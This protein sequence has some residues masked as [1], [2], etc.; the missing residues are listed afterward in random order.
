MLAWESYVEAQA[1]RAQGWTISAIARHLG[2]TRLTV[3]RYLSGERV[4]GQRARTEPDPFEE[5]VEYCRLRL[6]ADPH[7]WATTLFDEVTALG[8]A[9][10]Y[11]SFTRALRT[12]ELRPVCAACRSGK[13]G[14]RA[15]IDHPAG[16]ETQWDYLGATRGRAWRVNS[17]I[18]GRPMPD[19]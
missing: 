10:S 15:V 12:R 1:L 9:G 14:Q 8:Y 6:V 19:A 7:L 13:T 4:P 5:F 2:V 18:G 3:R 16:E 17:R 11:P